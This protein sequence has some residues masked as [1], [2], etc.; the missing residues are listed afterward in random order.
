YDDDEARDPFDFYE[1]DIYESSMDY[2]FTTPWKFG[3]G[4]ANFFGRGLISADAEIITYNSMKCSELSSQ[5]GGGDRYRDLNDWI[6]DTY[7][8]AVNLRWAGG[9]LFNIILSG[10]AGV[11]YF[12][13]PYQDA[14]DSNVSGS[15]GLGV[16]INNTL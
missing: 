4:V 15:Q 5:N 2:N 14:N 12:G 6:S 3:L 10:R 9:Y 7:G 8:T 11:A 16:K 13:S 1:S